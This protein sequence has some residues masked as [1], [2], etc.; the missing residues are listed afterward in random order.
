M[1]LASQYSV[2]TTQCSAIIILHMTDWLVR[3]SN[4]MSLPKTKEES[5]KILLPNNFPRTKHCSACHRQRGEREI[6]PLAALCLLQSFQ[7]KPNSAFDKKA[8]T[9]AQLAPAAAVSSSYCCPPCH[10]RRWH[11]WH[12]L[13]FIEQSRVEFDSIKS[14]QKILTC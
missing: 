3:L 12:Q 14:S 8:I 11:V 10:R 13:I 1:F 7:Q 2:A 4:R 9:R 6:Q 5:Q